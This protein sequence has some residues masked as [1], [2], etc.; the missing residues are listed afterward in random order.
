MPDTLYAHMIR[1]A[2]EEQAAGDETFF[3]TLDNMTNEQLVSALSKALERMEA[4][5]AGHP[6]SQGS[7]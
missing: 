2:A 1:I 3:D 4:E 6:H 7:T 5:R